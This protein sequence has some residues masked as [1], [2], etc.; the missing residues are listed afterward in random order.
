VN[1]VQQ[2]AYQIRYALFTILSVSLNYK[3]ILF[4]SLDQDNG[5]FSRLF[6][7]SADASS[8]Q[9][10]GRTSNLFSSVK[11]LTTSREFRQHPSTL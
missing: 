8:Y 3:P 5:K 9:L 1:A 10:A 2:L 7:L 6:V 4:P 11:S